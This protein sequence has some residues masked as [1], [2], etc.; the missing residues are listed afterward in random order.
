MPKILIQ[1][2]D[3]L[4]NVAIGVFLLR[5]IIDEISPSPFHPVTRLLYIITEPVLKPIRRIL[6]NGLK[7][8]INI[9]ISPIVAIL[10][11]IA[12]KLLVMKALTVLS[13]RMKGVRVRHKF[14]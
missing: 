3:V 8:V 12:L 7:S 1:F 14:K 11:I 6:P 10:L 4:F 2:L 5:L 13:P 9:D